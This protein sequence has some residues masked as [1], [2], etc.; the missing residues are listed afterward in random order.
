MFY[1]AQRPRGF[2]NEVNVYQFATHLAR[3]AW[4]QAHKDDGDVNSASRGAWS[5]GARE[6]RAIL[7]AKGDE[8]TAAYNVLLD[9]ETGEPVYCRE[10]AS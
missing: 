3:D 4:V 1:A 8:V 5:I 9:G 2:A 10:D 7:R 6:A